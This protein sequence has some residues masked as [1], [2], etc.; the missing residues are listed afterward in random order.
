MGMKG[1]TGHE[2]LLAAYWTIRKIIGWPRR[3]SWLSYL[4]YESISVF[5]TAGS[6]QLSRICGTKMVNYGKRSSVREAKSM[7][8]ETV[9]VRLWDSTLSWKQACLCRCPLTSCCKSR[10]E[11]WG[12]GRNRSGNFLIERDLVE[13]KVRISFVGRL[14]IPKLGD[15]KCLIFWTTLYSVSRNTS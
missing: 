12:S 10:A 5:S 4:K 3:N 7:A 1:K 6:L 8:F 15:A 13:T 11:M 9:R 14:Y 2:S